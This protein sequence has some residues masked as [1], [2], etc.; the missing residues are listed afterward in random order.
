MF[1]SGSVSISACSFMRG[2]SP[3][4]PAAFAALITCSG[5]LLPSPHDSWRLAP[6]LYGR[7]APSAL[8]NIGAPPCVLGLAAAIEVPNRREYCRLAVRGAAVVQGE[9]AV[10]RI[11]EPA[12][13]A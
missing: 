6:R 9:P 5:S 7:A 13:V 3:L 8:S 12:P 10:A 2:R 4:A 11:G 1:S